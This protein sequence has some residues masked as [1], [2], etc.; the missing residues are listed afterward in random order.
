MK[1]SCVIPARLKSTRFPRKILAMLHDRPLIQWVWE[2][3]RSVPL[4]DSVTIAVDAR[5]TATVVENFGGNY[6]MTSESCPSG[7]MRI[8]ELVQKN[9]IPGDIFVCWQG[10]EPF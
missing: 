2:A 4:F 7:T 8:A 10:D 3:A 9:L 1:I 6:L 5:E